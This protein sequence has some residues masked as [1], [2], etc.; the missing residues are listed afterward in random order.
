M[1]TPHVSPTY[2]PYSI[3]SCPFLLPMQSVPD[4]PVPQ[5][6]VPRA[7][8]RLGQ[9]RGVGPGGA[10][11][12]PRQPPRPGA[13]PQPLLLRT[14]LP[15]ALLPRPLRV[16]PPAPAPSPQ[17]QAPLP[18]PQLP[19]P[20]SAA[21]RGLNPYPAY[22]CRGQRCALLSRACGRPRRG[23]QESLL[24]RTMQCLCDL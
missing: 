13:D 21:W 8:A 24:H 1:Q 6:G 16:S 3:T 5:P 7:A 12:A 15:L 2:H 17:P 9:H 10:P 23:P 4:C 20:D 14:L 19:A 18:I 11:A 22:R